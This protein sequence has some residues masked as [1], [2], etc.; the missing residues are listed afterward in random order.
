MTCTCDSR[1]LREL[2]L[3]ILA[4]LTAGGVGNLSGH[5]SPEGVVTANPGQIYADIDTGSLYVK[6]TGTGNIGWIP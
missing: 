6:M 5:G 3:A 1:T 2:H 4:I